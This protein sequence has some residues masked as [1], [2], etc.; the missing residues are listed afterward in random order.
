MELAVDERDQTFEGTFVPLTPSEQQPGDTRRIV[1][2]PAILLG[3]SET[4]RTK[5]DDRGG[6]GDTWREIGGMADAPV[7]V[8]ESLVD[9][10]CP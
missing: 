9:G 3:S 6:P 10:G 1:G 7:T 8:V 4:V 2:N 5:V